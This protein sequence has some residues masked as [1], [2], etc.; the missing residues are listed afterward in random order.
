[1]ADFLLDGRAIDGILA[2]V[3]C[4]GVGLIA[5][6]LLWRRGPPTAALIGNLLSGGFLLVALRNALIGGSAALIGLCLTGALIAHLAD[7]LA[8]WETPATRKSTLDARAPVRATLS[9]RVDAANLRTAPR[10]RKS[11]SSDA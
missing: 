5:I 9:L 8:R 6:R 10:A 1:M 2:L 3:A 11:E 4:E 7:V